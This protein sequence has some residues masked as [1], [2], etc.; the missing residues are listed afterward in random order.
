MH[1]TATTQTE[2]AGQIQRRG[3]PIGFWFESAGGFSAQTVLGDFFALTLSALVSLVD[4]AGQI[5]E[6][7]AKARKRGVLPRQRINRSE[8]MPTH[9][10]G[11]RPPLGAFSSFLL[12]FAAAMIAARQRTTFSTRML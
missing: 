8:A 9:D 11:N 12:A 1:T 3:R 10:Q 7:K 4:H 6:M 5:V 2:G